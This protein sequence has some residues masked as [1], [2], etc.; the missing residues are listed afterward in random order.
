MV[1]YLT[2][3]LLQILV[4]SLSAKHEN[5]SAFRDVR[6]ESTVAC[7]FNSQ[8][9]INFSIFVC[10]SC[11]VAK[12]RIRDADTDSSQFIRHEKFI[13]SLRLRQTSDARYLTQYAAFWLPGSNHFLSVRCQCVRVKLRHRKISAVPA[14]A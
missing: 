4:S 11:R 5:R 14:S 1:G 13:R 12:T 8:C 9:T 7:F 3:T 10:R 2:I 6:V